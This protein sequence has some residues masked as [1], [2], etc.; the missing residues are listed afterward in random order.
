MS[1]LHTMALQLACSMQ[2]PSCS[3]AFAFCKP[4]MSTA[5]HFTSISSDQLESGL[6]RL[7]HK[8]LW[9]SGMGGCALF[10]SRREM[11]APSPC[12]KYASSAGTSGASTAAHVR[13]WS[14]SCALPGSTCKPHH[15]QASADGKLSSCCF[16]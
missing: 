6:R 15:S 11:A 1:M 12:P 9:C 3:E 16:V 14:S 7:R 13:C 8:L 5:L 2:S 10:P 4:T